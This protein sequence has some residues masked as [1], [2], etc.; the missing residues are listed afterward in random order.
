M[1]DPTYNRQY[2]TPTALH[3]RSGYSITTRGSDMDQIQFIEHG[4]V[5]HEQQTH[6]MFMRDQL[7]LETGLIVRCIRL[8][9]EDLLCQI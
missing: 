3:L 8:G 5:I 6:L 2:P 4:T 1:S 9:K 7:S